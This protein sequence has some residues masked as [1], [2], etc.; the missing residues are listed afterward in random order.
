MIIR[1]ATPA[2]AAAIW[3]VI[4]PAIRAGEVFAL[5][6]DLRQEEAIA[7]WTGKGVCDWETFV[8]EDESG[9]LLGTYYIRPNQSGGGRHIANAG[10]ATAEA[11]RGRGIA[12]ALCAHSLERARARGFRGM[13]FNFVV[14]TNARAV[15]LWESM[16]FAVVGRLP[17]AFEHPSQGFVDALVMFR[18]LPRLGGVIP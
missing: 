6:R 14:S 5:D 10:Y 7:Y 12:R 9:I 13:Q 4:G 8:A 16:G 17:Q 1:P 3:S 11:A 15:G 2:D 18:E